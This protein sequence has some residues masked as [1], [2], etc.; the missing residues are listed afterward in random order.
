MILLHPKY[1]YTLSVW[2]VW[3]ATRCTIILF[4]LL[5][6]SQVC[7][8]PCFSF[9]INWNFTKQYTTYLFEF[10]ASYFY[11]L[12]KR[13]E[14]GCSFAFLIIYILLY[15]YQKDHEDIHDLKNTSPKKISSASIIFFKYSQTRCSLLLIRLWA[16]F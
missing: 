3:D 10:L 7:L 9:S 2:V 11:G 12:Q 8:E 5:L 13:G 16:L 4:L 15:E 1:P 14:G 6:S